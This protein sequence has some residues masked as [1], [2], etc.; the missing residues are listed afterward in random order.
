MREKDFKTI[1]IYGKIVSNENDGRILYVY[2][3]LVYLFDIKKLG[4]IDILKD[5]WDLYCEIRSY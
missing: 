2:R 5:L 1:F 3:A 4:H